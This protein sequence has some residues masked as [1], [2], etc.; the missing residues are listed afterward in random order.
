MLEI[1]EGLE[2]ILP[3]PE[4][5]PLSPESYES[6]QVQWEIIGYLQ[7]KEP[8]ILGSGFYIATELQHQDFQAGL[9]EGRYPASELDTMMMQ[10]QDPFDGDEGQANYTRFAN[11]ISDSQE[12]ERIILEFMGGEREHLTPAD[13]ARYLINFPTPQDVDDGL[14]KFLSNTEK[15]LG[16]DARVNAEEALKMFMD[17]VYGDRFKYWQNFKLMFGE[18]LDENK[19]GEVDKVKSRIGRK[20]AK[21][22][23]KIAL[24]GS[25][26]VGGVQLGYGYGYQQAESEYGDAAVTRVESELENETENKYGIEILDVREGYKHLGTD[27][28]VYDQKELGNHPPTKW[29]E[30]QIKLLNELLARFPEKFYKPNGETKLNFSLTDY[31]EDCPCAGTFHEK[32]MI[33]LSDGNFQRD[34]GTWPFELLAHELAHRMDIDVLQEKLWPKVNEILGFS[35]FKEAREHYSPMLTEAALIDKSLSEMHHRFNYGF[36]GIRNT[37][38]DNPTEFIA[39]MVETY[40][41]G[42]D[43]FME[44][45][46]FLGEK[47]AEELYDLVKNEMFD[48]MEFESTE[49]VDVEDVPT[50][51]SDDQVLE[52]QPQDIQ[53]QE[54]TLPQVEDI[55]LI[56]I[57][58]GENPMDW[59]DDSR[60]EKLHSSLGNLPSGFFLPEVDNDGNDKKLKIL[61]GDKIELEGVN[62][63]IIDK[64]IIDQSEM[65]SSIGSRL[66]KR[67]PYFEKTMNGVARI[68]GI[69]KDDP[70]LDEFVRRTISSYII[71]E[72]SNNFMMQMSAFSTEYSNRA[73]NQ[74]VPQE[75]FDFIRDNLF[76]GR[77]Y[78][79]DYTKNQVAFKPIGS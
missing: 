28:N 74:G 4:P 41:G 6:Q 57:I 14:E 44:T 3:S 13:I 66:A 20:V 37:G 24:A 43:K 67:S 19:P 58:E 54:L 33:F 68:Y 60:L 47:K 26:M 36:N 40:V 52:I 30:D 62:K 22:M 63:L 27:F 48:G 34:N 61:L 21:R 56:D 71:S 51:Q 55:F 12:K 76:G 16:T 23:A 72:D 35:T 17:G 46:V 31:G 15:G 79:R 1:S 9:I 69:S 59:I 11:Q 39:I 2:S 49:K 65:I 7:T 75:A 8:K 18:A 38:L 70:K 50:Q 25:V 73:F 45:K 32:D 10:I 77:T 78:I 29:S 42:K 64:D 5:S 53:E